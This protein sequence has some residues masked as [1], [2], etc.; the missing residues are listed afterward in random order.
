MKRRMRVV[1][2]IGAHKTGSSLV[3]KFLRDNRPALERKGLHYIPRRETNTLVGWGK[4]LRN[5]PERL[6]GRLEGVAA[7]TYRAAVV[8]HEN[9]MGRP[10]VRDVPG[11]YPGAQ[12]NLI[13]LS[14]I[15]EGFDYRVVLY[16]RPQADFV[17]SC[18]LQTLHEGGTKT[19]AEW[20]TELVRLEDLSWRP[21]VA[22]M[23][24]AFGADRTIVKDFNDIKLGQDEYLRRFFAAVGVDP[25]VAVSYKPVRN[26]SVSDK[27]MQMALAINSLIETP[28][29]RK[30]ARVFLQKHFSNRSYPRPRLF[31]EAQRQQIADLYDEEYRTWRFS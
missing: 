9:S 28:E 29:Q 24:E 7:Q 31:T 17:E 5:E 21:L 10:F 30:A 22:T 2:H 26:P 15:L 18:Y 20:T 19:F 1:F 16:I 25:G 14:Q 13:A 12:H 3:Q 23:H 6:R 4:A 11:L 8:S 27:G